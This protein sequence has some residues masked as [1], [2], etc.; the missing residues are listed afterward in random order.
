VE[1][2]L[3]KYFYRYF[4]FTTVS[5]SILVGLLWISVVLYQFENRK[6]RHL[7]SAMVLSKDVSMRLLQRIK[8]YESILLI[9]ARV[10][11]KVEIK[12]IDSDFFIRLI[13][14]EAM[15]ENPEF[16]Q[17]RY[18]DSKGME[19]YRM[20]RVAD[21]I[22]FLEE[23]KL[24][25]KKNRYYYKETKKLKDGEVYLSPIDLNVEHGKIEEPWV[26]TL[27]IS[28]PILDSKNGGVG[29]VIININLAEDL[30]SLFTQNDDENIYLLNKDGYFLTGPDPSALWGFMLGVENSLEVVNPEVWH[31]LKNNFYG[32]KIQKK[33]SFAYSSIDVNNYLLDQGSGDF[34]ASDF[35]RVLVRV[36]NSKPVFTPDSYLEVLFSLLIF[37]AI[38]YVSYFISRVVVHKRLAEISAKWSQDALVQ[39][40]KMASLGRLVAGV[41]HELNTPIGSSVTIAST[42]QDELMIFSNE[43]DTGQI[44]KSSIT[45]YLESAKSCTEVMME[46]L[47]RSSDLVTHFKRV[48]VDQSSES[49]RKFLLPDYIN[50]IISTLGPMLKNKN[51][52]I[53]IISPESIEMDSFPGPFAQVIT[54]LINNAVIH[55]FPDE[56]C[57]TIS[58]TLSKG[59][60][61]LKVSVRDDGVGILPEN[62][63]RIF[64]PFFTTAS[65][66]GGSGLGMHIVYNIVSEV[67]NGTVCVK[68][69]VNEFTEFLV[70]IPMSID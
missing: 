10:L 60:K 3:K 57:G 63:D 25:N 61:D 46:C 16:Y 58:V 27:R 67:L 50:D 54:N 21:D 43:V 1:I 36:K 34:V 12:D 66:I 28:T 69:E 64:D 53:E 7:E 5:L 38:I 32:K 24:Q 62:I 51:I 59:N 48:S 37:T 13:F 44:R 52:A 47:Q 65:K 17:L 70:V 22:F 2:K 20:D 68:S 29:V 35:V 55:A 41:A 40:E 49:R 14:T 42:L 11:E 9:T 30:E 31:E 26:P 33:Y 19:V 23:E 39:S 45:R 8:T 18:I 15:F 56:G 6:E 4:I